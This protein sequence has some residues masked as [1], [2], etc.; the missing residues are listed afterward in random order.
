MISSWETRTP[1]PP[2]PLVPPAFQLPQRD[3]PLR[4]ALQ[5]QVVQVTGFD[6]L[7]RT[8][9]PITGEAGSTSDLHQTPCRS[10]EATTTSC[11]TS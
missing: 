11:T 7:V 8:V 6:E 4:Q 5:H 2:T 1:P 10:V 3:G 9:E